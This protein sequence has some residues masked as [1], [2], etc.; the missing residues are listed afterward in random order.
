MPNDDPDAVLVEVPMVK[1]VDLAGNYSLG[2]AIDGPRNRPLVAIADVVKGNRYGALAAFDLSTWE[3]V[4]L[5]KS[6]AK[7]SLFCGPDLELWLYKRIL[8]EDCGIEVDVG[9]SKNGSSKKD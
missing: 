6:A 7:V 2:L 5:T 4:F 9:S 1:H 3:R 8:S